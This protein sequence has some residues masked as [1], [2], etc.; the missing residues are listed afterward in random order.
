VK[1]QQIQPRLRQDLSYPRP[2]GIDKKSDHGDERRN[3]S[4]D[5][6]G[7]LWRDG[8]RAGGIKIQPDGID[9]IPHRAQR[10]LDAGDS[11]D[12]HTGS[13]WAL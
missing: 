4:G 2:A 5:A 8:P 1:L 9:P 3:M 7:L 12:L 11:A 6:F 10:I 13:H